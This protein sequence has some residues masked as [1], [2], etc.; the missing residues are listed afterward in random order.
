MCESVDVSSGSPSSKPSPSTIVFVFVSFLFV[1]W[2]LCLSL[3]LALLL[4]LQSSTSIW[5]AKLNSDPQSSTPLGKSCVFLGSTMSSKAQLWSDPWKLWSARLTC[6]PSKLF[7]NTSR[8]LNWLEVCGLWVVA[9]M[10]LASLNKRWKAKNETS[11]DET[12]SASL[13]KHW[14]NHCNWW[15]VKHLE[16]KPECRLGGSAGRI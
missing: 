15:K 6:G 9:P 1:L 11:A 3:S 4:Q 8:N 13:N 7:W 5:S 10:K 14:N 12:S 16:S 2:F